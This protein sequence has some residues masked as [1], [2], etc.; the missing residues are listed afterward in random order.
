MV[1]LSVS[2]GMVATGGYGGVLFQCDVCWELGDVFVIYVV[3]RKFFKS[4][5]CWLCW[6]VV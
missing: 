4:W 1:L 3:Y 2:V 5:C 6:H